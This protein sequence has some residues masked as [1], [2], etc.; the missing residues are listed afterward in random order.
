MKQFTVLQGN[1]ARVAGIG[2]NLR[3]G[4]AE[5]GACGF[6]LCRVRLP[7]KKPNKGDRYYGNSPK[8][9]EFTRFSRFRSFVFIIL[10]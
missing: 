3:K 4:D 1:P 2:Q 6:D 8:Q 10:N 5:A 9:S 7:K